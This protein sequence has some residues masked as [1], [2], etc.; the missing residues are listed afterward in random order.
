MEEQKKGEAVK[1]INNPRSDFFRDKVA[2]ISGASR[3]VGYATAKQLVEAGAKVIITARGERRLL[4]SRDKLIALG[5]EVEA[6][7]GDV[8]KCED[9]K[10]MVDAAI[11]RFGRLDILVNNAGISMRGKFHELAP[12][13]CRQT[14]ETNL[15]GSV[16]LS[17]AAVDHIR[18][19]QGHIVFISSIAGLFG[20][21]GA[22][23]YCASKSA[24]TGLCE[25][26]RIELIPEG[27]HLGVVYLG[28]TEHDPEKR[29][30]DA[31][32]A[33]VKPDRPAHHTQAYAASLVIDMLLKRKKQLIM[34]PVGKFGALVH[35]L[36]PRFVEWVILKAQAGQ[37]G[38]FKE[39]S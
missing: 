9:A 32:G 39:F 7:T 21:P 4:E 14:I 6:L 22:S 25:S 2:L 16:Y 26:M 10:A 23:T 18:A 38:P 15:L 35:R 29:I 24:L 20:M 5:G 28:F 34:T 31:D 12:E 17:R 30:L 11:A 1:P 13:V 19:A 36:S 3:G 33:P 27:V 37:W 8:G